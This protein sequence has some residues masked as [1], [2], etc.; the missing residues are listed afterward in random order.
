[1]T[2]A[3]RPPDRWAH[4]RWHWLSYY[5]RTDLLVS[6]WERERWCMMSMPWSFSADEMA[7]NG[8]NYHAPCTSPLDLDAPATVEAVAE[9]LMQSQ[10]S[11]GEYLDDARAVLA[12]IKEMQ[13]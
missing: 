12:R 9:V 13:G 8:F 11:S 3:L 4:L 5:H 6:K 2:D 10:R 7:L 1:M